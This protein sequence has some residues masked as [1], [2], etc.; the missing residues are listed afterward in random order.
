[1]TLGPRAF[2]ATGP[3]RADTPIVKWDKKFGLV[4]V[5]PL[6]A[7]TKKDVW[8]RIP[9][10]RSPTIHSMTRT[11]RVSAASLARGRY[12][13]VRTSGLAD[14]RFHEDRVRAATGKD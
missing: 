4:K 10:N 13:P 5:S 12:N 11:T 9:T 8:K 3:T 1:M 14:E 2:A 7:W 6:A